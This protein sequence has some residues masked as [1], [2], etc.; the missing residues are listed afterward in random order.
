MLKIET[1]SV[2]DQ[3][4]LKVIGRVQSEN[5]PELAAQMDIHDANTV[6]D[7]GEV[8]LVDVEVVRFLIKVES[9]GT[10][11]RNCPA[12]IREWMTCERERTKRT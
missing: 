8:T 12:Y 7:V 4:I 9:S 2:G 1:L 10:R 3:T 6:L 11:L 5:L